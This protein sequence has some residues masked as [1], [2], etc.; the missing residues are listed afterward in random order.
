MKIVEPEVH[1]LSD[2]NGEAFLHALEYA[3]RTCYK[4]TSEYTPESR[5]KFAKMILTKNHESVIEHVGFTVKFVCDRGVSHE[6]VRHRLASFSQESTRYCN[7]DKDKFGN[8][9]TVIKPLFF[10]DDPHH[11]QGVDEGC[12]DCQKYAAWKIAMQSCESAYRNL[13]DLGAKPE[14][15]RSVLPNSLKTEIVV[16][17]NLREW[18]KIFELRTSP[19]AHPQMRQVMQPLLSY[20]H[21]MIPVVFDEVAARL[22]CLPEKELAKPW[23]KVFPYKEM[24]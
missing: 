3:G 8:E 16:T 14:E 24:T 1:I 5:R 22:E 13:I 10:Q 17:A 18:K 19:S 4:S 12:V 7:Y 20:I 11:T 15:A 9:I 23:A 21:K 6:L 2:I